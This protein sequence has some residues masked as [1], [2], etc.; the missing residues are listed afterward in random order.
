MGF[1][2]DLPTDACT[3]RY[4]TVPGHALYTIW[5]QFYTVLHLW[6][7]KPTACR[8]WPS[9]C[10][11]VTG[12]DCGMPRFFFLF[13]LFFFC[14]LWKIDE[15]IMNISVEKHR[16]CKYSAYAAAV[17]RLC[18]RWG[19]MNETHIYYV[20]GTCFTA[21]RLGQVAPS[22]SQSNTILTVYWVNLGSSVYL[23]QP[24]QIAIANGLISTTS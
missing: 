24:A 1:Y 14:S 2:A 7:Y 10:P 21:C 23:L 5:T 4:M 6:P 3:P 13:F 16:P 9:A 12:G 11:E 19:S 20:G 15:W 8:H 22:W 18:T 17:P